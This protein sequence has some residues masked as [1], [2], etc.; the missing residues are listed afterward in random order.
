MKKKKKGVIAGPIQLTNIQSG[1]EKEVFFVFV[2]VF[3]SERKSR[4]K[5]NNN[6]NNKP[7]K[8]SKHKRHLPTKE[9]K[10]DLSAALDTRGQLQNIFKVLMVDF[11]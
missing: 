5:T 10:S 9:Q 2:F 4:I 1:E 7:I 6:N 11:F 3:L 8:V